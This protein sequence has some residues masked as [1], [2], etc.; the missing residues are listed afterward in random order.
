[1]GIKLVNGGKLCDQGYTDDLVFVW[2]HGLANCALN[3][4]PKSTRLAP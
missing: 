1:M 3:D 2:I 4:T